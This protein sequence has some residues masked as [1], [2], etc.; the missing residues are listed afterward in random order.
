MEV[1]FLKKEKKKMQVHLFTPI[2]S[3]K[4]LNHPPRGLLLSSIEQITSKSQAGQFSKMRLNSVA[5]E[6]YFGQFKWV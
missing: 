1:F 2:K 3:S 4:H 5:W 6:L